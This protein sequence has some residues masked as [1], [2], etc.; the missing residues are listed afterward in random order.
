MKI[1]FISADSSVYCNG[2]RSMSSFIKKK[3]YQSSIFFLPRKFGSSSLYSNRVL[4]NLGVLIDGDIVGVSCDFSNHVGATQIVDFVKKNTNVPVI[5]GGVHATLSPNNCLKHAD[6]VC[7]GEGEEAIAELMDNISIGKGSDQIDNIWLKDN[8]KVIRNSV[9]CPVDLDSLPFYDY[10]EEDKW[11]LENNRIG[12]FNNQYIKDDVFNLFVLEYFRREMNVKD[13]LLYHDGRG[14]PH[15]CYFCCNSSI[16]VLYKNY[17]HRMVRRKS[18]SYM[19]GELKYILNQ[20]NGAS[21]IMF[22]DDSFFLRDVEELKSFSELYK[23]DINL[24]FACYSHPNHVAEDKLEILFDAGLKKVTLGIQGSNEVNGILYNRYVTR[25]SIVTAANL[26]SSRK[27]CQEYQVIVSNPYEKESGLVEIINLLRRLPKPFRL[28]VFS[29]VLFPGSVIYE[30]ALSDGLADEGNNVLSY[31]ETAMMLKRRYKKIDS[32]YLNYIL[33][34]MNGTI[35]HRKYGVIPNFLLN[36]VLD[37]K[38]NNYIMYKILCCLSFFTYVLSNAR[39][40]EL[41]IM[42]RGCFG[43]QKSS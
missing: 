3:G 27:V 41:L 13:I 10:E 22:T 36:F 25:K 11:I 17:I 12:P 2:I 30:R 42:M 26:L 16:N 34:L 33:R 18:I 31:T 20:V 15:S 24:P 23:R 6:Y 35:T 4:D 40:R 21:S 39:I 38:I 8:D 43:I 14:C 1:N 9:R 32:L 29:L 5:W 19:I 28:Q 37:H 7:I